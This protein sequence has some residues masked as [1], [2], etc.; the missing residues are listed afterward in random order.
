MSGECKCGGEC[1]ECWC[2]K[3]DE[4]E[5][6]AEDWL[7]DREVLVN[8]P[9]SRE[10][11]C[12]A[13]T[14]EQKAGFLAGVEWERKRREEQNQKFAET[15]LKGL[16]EIS[17]KHGGINRIDGGRFIAGDEEEGEE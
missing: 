1:G 17:K 9:Y 7:G 14:T 4:A 3:S 16:E 15:V 8:F 2:V 11:V 6:A 12:Q 10:G 5:K 13:V